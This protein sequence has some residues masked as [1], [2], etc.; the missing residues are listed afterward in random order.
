M[1]KIDI[2]INLE[3]L[4][5]SDA[6]KKHFSVYGFGGMFESVLI[7]GLNFLYPDGLLGVKHRI[8]NR[9]LNKLD[10]LTE[11][12]SVLELEESEIDLIKSVFLSDK[13]C[14]QASQTRLICQYVELIDRLNL[15]HD[16]REA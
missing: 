3:K 8:L 9:I 15:E 13:A 11:N 4:K 7:Q 1:K 14:F 5:L 10:S 6:E 16:K 12:N 2:V